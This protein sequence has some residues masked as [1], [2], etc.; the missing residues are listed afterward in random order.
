ML[1]IIFIFFQN[2]KQMQSNATKKRHQTKYP[3]EK[4]HPYQH[5]FCFNTSTS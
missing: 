4:D 1:S 2:K 3:V 5:S